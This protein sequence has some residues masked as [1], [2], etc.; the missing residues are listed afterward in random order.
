M[1]DAIEAEAMQAYLTP[2][3]EGEQQVAEPTVP[4]AEEST[5]EKGDDGARLYF[6]KDFFKN[7]EEQRRFGRSLIPKS[8]EGAA[9]AP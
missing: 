1:D 8:E 7:E 2:V 3:P 4:T 5:A 6:D 9:P